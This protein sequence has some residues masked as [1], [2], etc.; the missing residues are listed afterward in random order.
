MVRKGGGVRIE[1][2]LG[3][4]SYLGLYA[5]FHIFISTLLF[6]RDKRVLARVFYG[7]AGVLNLIVLYNTATRGAIL[8]LFGGAIIAAAL[9]A[10]FEKEWGAQRKIALGSVLAI[11]ALVGGL[12]IFHNAP[13]ITSNPVLARIASVTRVE[14]VLQEMSAS[15]FRIWEMGWKGF[16]EHP[17]LGWGQENFNLVFSKYYDPRMYGQEPWFDRAHNVVFDRLVDG[18]T[19]G[20][21]SYLSIF[22]SVIYYLWFCRRKNESFAITERALFTGLLAAYFFQNLF[23][24]DQFASYFLFFSVLAFLH[25]RATESER[26]SERLEREAFE[27]KDYIAAALIVVGTVAVL[28]TVSINGIRANQTLLEAIRPQT[29]G[30]GKNLEYFKRALAYDH[31]VGIMETREQLVTVSAGLA[32]M[33]DNR[34]T[35]DDLFV[36]A[37][38]EMRKQVNLQPMDARYHLFLANLFTGYGAI[39]DAI[40]ELQQGIAVSPKKEQFYY[41]LGNLYFSIGKYERAIEVFRVPFENAPENNQSRTLYAAAAIYAGKDDI[42]EKTLKPMG[43]MEEMASIADTIFVNAY[44]SRGQFDKVAEIWERRVA[45]DPNS[46]QAYLSLAAAY[47]KLGKSQKAIDTVKKVMEIA[48]DFKQQGEELIRRI[49]DGDM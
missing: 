23:I 31:V 18:G 25:F 33:Q 32:S 11:V 43:G 19:L 20:L 46:P 14:S 38:E 16:K 13:F 27:Q 9:I 47:V 45:K 10:I 41:L 3:N 39:E 35:K 17:V 8:G 4:A 2:T 5:L 7:T 6:V 48:P 15:R 22:L 36:L 37:K 34:Q 21:L 12:V 28:Y 29:E 42:A 44:V 49:K 24:F 1:A 26:T 40:S 30:I